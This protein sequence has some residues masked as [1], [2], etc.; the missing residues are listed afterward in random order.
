MNVRI[1]FQ[2]ANGAVIRL[3]PVSLYPVNQPMRARLRLPPGRGQLVFTLI[4]GKGPLAVRV[5]P[6][7]WLQAE[8]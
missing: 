5:G 8:P 3:A 6:I 4:G 2:P 7:T 1:A